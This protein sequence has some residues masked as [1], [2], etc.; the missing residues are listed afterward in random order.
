MPDPRNMT[1]E[2]RAQFLLANL[3]E[4][5]RPTQDMLER[6]GRQRS[7]A[8]LARGEAHTA[9]LADAARGRGELE[10]FG[11]RTR[12]AEATLPGTDV[13]YSPGAMVAG[14]ADVL[15]AGHADELGGA[16][17]A[18]RGGDYQRRRDALRRTASDARE[19]YPGS[20]GVGAAAAIPL[21]AMAAPVQSTANMTRAM[22]LGT[23]A[24]EGGIGA[25][26]A[27]S[28]FSE[29]QLG[30]PRRFEE[31]ARDIAEGMAGGM[32]LE[33][34]GQGYRQFRQ[35]REG[36]RAADV[37]AR[38]NARAQADDAVAAQARASERETARR[39]IDADDPTFV[40]GDER[41]GPGSPLRDLAL[42]VRDGRQ[43][44]WSAGEGER[45]Q[46]LRQHAE[47]AADLR[48][49][50]AQ[51]PASRGRRQRIGRPADPQNPN[52]TAAQRPQGAREADLRQNLRDLIGDQRPITPE[53]V[54]MLA[55]GDVTGW[56]MGPG[57]APRS[58]DPTVTNPRRVSYPSG[59]AIGPR[60]AQESAD[61]DAMM[62]RLLP[63]T[64]PTPSVA[65]PRAAL[66]AT[67]APPRS[68]SATFGLPAWLVRDQDAP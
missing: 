47:E 56:E 33:L 15:T 35:A 65:T 52:I 11:D 19:R 38:V 32:G 24:L 40:L 57:R 26:I 51:A 66:P 13:T 25:G 5:A 30:D 3:L 45:I 62:E 58:T 1:E 16:V 64:Q 20:Y 44:R 8:A 42:G 22:A 36:R 37:D 10:T 54:D 28:G 49:Q 55:R 61:L 67:G 68:P 17:A 7:A 14:G 63:P 46:A 9:G 18:M 6:Q 60:G 29:Y 12:L 23:R 50:I 41:F 48:R 27:S 31:G 34:L 59:P 4:N 39:M 21:A 43:A 53:D 2:Q